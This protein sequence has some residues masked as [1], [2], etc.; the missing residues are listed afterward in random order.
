[1]LFIFGSY[2]GVEFVSVVKIPKERFF[3]HEV[4]F[5]VVATTDVCG[6]WIVEWSTGSTVEN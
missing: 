6:V 1:M 2:D 3:S 5:V 4:A